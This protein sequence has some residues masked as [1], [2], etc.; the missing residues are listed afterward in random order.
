MK[1]LVGVRG[2]EP[3]AP[4]SGGSRSGDELMAGGKKPGK[5]T[6]MPKVEGVRFADPN[7]AIYSTRLFVGSRHLGPMSGSVKASWRKK[8]LKRM[9]KQEKNHGNNL[10]KRDVRTL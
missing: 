7:S 2:F 4:A 5:R 8:I 3:P 6:R 10:S 9:T 1:V